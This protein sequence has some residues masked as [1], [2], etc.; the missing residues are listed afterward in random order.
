MGICPT[1]TLIAH[2]LPYRADHERI[3]FDTDAPATTS[4]I[5]AI[6]CT[7]DCNYDGSRL[8]G[9]KWWCCNILTRSRLTQRYQ[10]GVTSE[11]F[12]RCARWR[13]ALGGCIEERHWPI[14]GRGAQRL[15]RSR[16][17][18]TAADGQTAEPAE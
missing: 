18:P 12:Q 8:S 4:P 9:A 13:F 17:F 15:L 11:R 5:G 14:I 6:S 16:L 2:G 10:P 1:V 3:S 7:V